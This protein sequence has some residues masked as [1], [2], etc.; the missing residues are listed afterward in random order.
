MPERWL[1]ALETTAPDPVAAFR[2]IEV[3]KFISVR[4]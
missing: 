2:N 3:G 4:R 1:D